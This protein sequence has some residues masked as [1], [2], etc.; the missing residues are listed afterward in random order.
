MK[1]PWYLRTGRVVKFTDG[2]ITVEGNVSRVWISW[3][4]FRL[5]VKA[6]IGRN[7]AGPIDMG[8]F[9][10]NAKGLPS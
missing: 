9:K 5:A 7:E 8:K 4:L 3:V 1:F 6:L 2:S 10:D